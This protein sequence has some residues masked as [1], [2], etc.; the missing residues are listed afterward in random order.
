[1]GK[2]HFETLAV[3]GGQSPDPVTKARG[4]LFGELRH[5]I[6]IHLNMGKSFCTKRIRL[7]LHET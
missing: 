7:H 2:L 1:M 6:L 4:S 5:T 3:H